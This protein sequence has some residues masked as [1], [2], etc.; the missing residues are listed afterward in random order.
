MLRSEEKV[1]SDSISVAMGFYRLSTNKI[2]K[3]CLSNSSRSFSQQM[4]KEHLQEM[5]EAGGGEECTD[6]QLPEVIA[7]T[8]TFHSVR[9]YVKDELCRAILNSG[10]PFLNDALE[11]LEALTIPTLTSE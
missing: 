10:E 6:S 8:D 9:N 3:R 11:H 7:N 1:D 4:R 5:G 2:V